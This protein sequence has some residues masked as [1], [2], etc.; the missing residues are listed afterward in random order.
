M[1]LIAPFRSDVHPAGSVP[2]GA[3][4]ASGLCP[5][6][7]S[8][9]SGGIGSGSGRRDRDPGRRYRTEQMVI[10]TRCVQILDLKNFQLGSWP[11]IIAYCQ[12][13]TQTDAKPRGDSSLSPYGFLQLWRWRL[14]NLADSIIFT[15]VKWWIDVTKLNCGR[16][17]SRSSQESRQDST[18]INGRAGEGRGFQEPESPHSGVTCLSLYTSLPVSIDE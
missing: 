9:P 5:A 2:H 7:H 8:W 4:A 16:R 15:N 12:H 14:P 10:Q 17:S 11:N 18:A 1:S 13:N 6:A 3:A